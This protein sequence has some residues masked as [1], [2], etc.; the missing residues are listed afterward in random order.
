M[1]L[2]AED[3][4]LDLAVERRASKQFAIKQEITFRSVDAGPPRRGSGHNRN[5]RGDLCELA[6]AV[7]WHMRAE[8]RRTVSCGGMKLHRVAVI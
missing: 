8:I 6:G 1:S 3:E 5:A 2:M 4:R 7:K